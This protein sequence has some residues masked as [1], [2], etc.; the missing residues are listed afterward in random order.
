MKK[1]T[2][3]VKEATLRAWNDSVEQC[4]LN[5]QKPHIHFNTF[6]YRVNAYVNGISNAQAYIPLDGSIGRRLREL[7]AEGL[8]DYD[9]KDEIYIAK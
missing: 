9:Y 8:V 4:V 6:R 5:G 2:I 1:G 3:S 7:R